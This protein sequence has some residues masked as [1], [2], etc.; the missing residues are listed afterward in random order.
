M[1][2]LSFAAILVVI[3]ASSPDATPLQTARFMF[4]SR[5]KTGIIRADGT[6]LS[7]FDFNVPNQA[8]WQPGPFFSDGR[9]LVFLSMEPR[10]DGPGRPFE[11]FYT[12]APTHIWLH[13]LEGGSLDE[14]C[15]KDR[16]APF[17]TPALLVNDERLL[18]QVVK[19]KVAR[20]VNMRLDGSD[21]RDFT[22]AGE[23][24][25]YGFSLSPD[26]K[27]VAFHLAGPEGYRVASSGS[28]Y[29]IRR[30]WSERL[31]A[32]F[33]VVLLGGCWSSEPAAAPVPAAGAPFRRAQADTAVADLLGLMRERLLL[34]H[35]VA[36]CK[37]NEGKPITDPNREQQLLAE[38]EQRGLA[39]GLSRK[40]AR[41]FMAAQM[42][43]GKLV[44]Q[45]DFARWKGQGQGTFNNVRDL[46]TELRPLIDDLSDRMLAQLAKVA[47]VIDDE[48]MKASL[49]QRAD[50]LVRG[51]GIDGTVR[52]TAIR[53]LAG[54]DQARKPI[55]RQR[56]KHPVEHD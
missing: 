41:N 39:Y 17:E 4:T 24:V 46:N 23:G 25:P 55:A 52:S 53:P 54:G 34:M 6:S 31:L 40:H 35:E 26:G 14:I 2:F 3:P 8:T 56:L 20:V 50:E 29:G 7:Y 44:Q 49:A 16:I 12:Q 21:A 47:P 38:L 42:A 51:E 5:G 48:Q 22:R 27:R 43:A 30:R 15:T 45:A 9:R 11:E 13:D 28:N 32:T 36:R 18:V 19:D 10:R 1:Y 33:F 37:W